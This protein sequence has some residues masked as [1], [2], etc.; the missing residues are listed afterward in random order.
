MVPTGL[1]VFSRVCRAF[2]GRVFCKLSASACSFS[3]TQVYKLW[4]CFRFLRQLQLQNI[5]SFNAPSHYKPRALSSEVIC[6]APF[7]LLRPLLPQNTRGPSWNFFYYLSRVEEK[8]R[9]QQT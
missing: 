4:V 8:R 6:L 7:K 1:S 5:E 9:Q 2:Q 3:I